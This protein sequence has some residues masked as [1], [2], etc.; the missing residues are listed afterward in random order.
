MRPAVSA[1]TS[2]GPT[3]R[4]QDL[5]H[6]RA[7][8][9]HGVSDPATC[10]QQLVHIHPSGLGCPGPGRERGIEGVDVDREVNGA[11]ADD[12]R[13]P[14]DDRGDP[15]LAHV[16]HEEARDP[17]G[18]LP[19]ELRLAGPVPAEADLGVAAGVDV[20]L[21]DQPAHRRAVRYLDAPELGRG[22]GVGVEMDQAK[23]AFG[24]APAHARLRD[25]VV[26]AEDQRD[27]A[28]ASHLGD[29]RL[30]SP[31]RRGGIGR[32]DGRVTVVDHGQVRVPVDARLQVSTGIGALGADRAR[33][34]ARPGAVRGELVHR[35]PDD[36]GIACGEVVG[37]LRIGHAGEREQ[38]RVGRRAFDPEPG[39]ALIWVDR[40][41][42]VTL[43]PRPT[44]GRSIGG[45]RTSRVMACARW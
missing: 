24:G 20:A 31:V 22:V 43:V 34:H 17:H 32:H 12:L 38:A 28:G 36:G 23:R 45:R 39:P 2:T 41:D 21:L 3:A 14:F 19:R 35:G 37:I 40:G 5:D 8:E 7:D 33:P 42:P 11:V 4:G 9:L 10:G 27:R 13:R 29:D 26:A 25:R 1:V 16:M 18:L 44:N 15:E 30:D 6:V